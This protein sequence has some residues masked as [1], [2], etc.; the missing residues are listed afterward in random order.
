MDA[1]DR[2]PPERAAPVL[3]TVCAWCD[4]VL[5]DGAEPVSGGICSACAHRV[6]S[7]NSVLKPVMIAASRRRASRPPLRRH[8]GRGGEAAR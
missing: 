6:L 3:R 1:D 5:H 2:L 7:Q 8:A 4:A